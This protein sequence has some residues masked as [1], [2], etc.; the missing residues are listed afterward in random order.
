[1]NQV[2][3]FYKALQTDNKMKSKFKSLAKIVSR[4]EMNEV[5]A[6]AFIDNKV[7]PIAKEFGFNIT[8]ADLL[9]YE[10]S[11]CELGDEELAN[12]SG[13]TMS[14][15]FQCNSIFEKLGL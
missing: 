11:V 14:N 15:S 5:E 13:G 1:M 4:T 3:D 9:A 8:F 6:E 12:V 2:L 10:H 7:L